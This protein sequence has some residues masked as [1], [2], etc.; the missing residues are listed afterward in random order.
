MKTLHLALKG[1]WYDMIDR[2]TEC[3]RTRKYLK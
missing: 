3:S 2:G 1:K